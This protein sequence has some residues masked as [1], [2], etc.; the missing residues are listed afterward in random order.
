M[1][2]PAD[3]ILTVGRNEYITPVWHSQLLGLAPKV[4]I[5]V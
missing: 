4:D 2:P 1:L 5:F 3:V